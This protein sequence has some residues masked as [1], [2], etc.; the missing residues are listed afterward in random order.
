MPAMPV[1]VLETNSF[2][3]SC[4]FPCLNELRNYSIQL[5]ADCVS[6]LQF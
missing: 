4:L 3:L 2:R 1:K 5:K 6:K